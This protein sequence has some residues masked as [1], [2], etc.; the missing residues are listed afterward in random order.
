[1]SNK[2][3]AFLDEGTNKLMEV[4]SSADIEEEEKVA[5]IAAFSDELSSHIGSHSEMPDYEYIISK[6]SIVYVD[7]KL[8]KFSA[9]QNPSY[10][11]FDTSLSLCSRLKSL[12]SLFKKKGW[13]LPALTINDPDEFEASV[14]QHQDTSLR[15]DKLKKLDQQID[16]AISR[17]EKELTI[18]RCHEVVVLLD[19]MQRELELAGKKSFASQLKNS[20]TKALYKRVALLRKTAEQKQE[21]HCSII[22]LDGKLRA[23]DA[24][25]PITSVNSTAIQ[26]QEAIDIC[27]QL[28][29]LFAECKKKQWG[30]PPVSYE[31]PEI[32]RKKYSHYQAMIAI[33]QSITDCTD[34]LA[35]KKQYSWYISQCSKQV[36]NIELCRT[37]KWAIPTLHNPS[38]AGLIEVAKQKMAEKER[39]Q[40]LKG[41]LILAGVIALAVLVLIG[42][43]VVKSREGKITVPFSP[44]YAVSENCND[45][46]TELE[47]AGFTNIKLVESDDGWLESGDVIS[48]TVDNVDDYKKGSYFKPEVT[49]VITYSSSN[50]IDASD[51]LKDWQSRDYSSIVEDLKSEGFTQITTEA[52]TT[53]EKN[54]DQKIS[55]ISLND[56]AYTNGHCYLP[57]DAPIHIGYYELKIAA[58]NTNISFVGQNYTDV[59]NGLKEDGFTNV[60]TEEIKTGWAEGN[61]VIAVTFNNQTSYDS[62][63]NFSPDVKIVVKYSSNDRADA[64]ELLSNWSAMSYDKLQKSLKDAGFT[65]VTVKKTETTTKSQNHLVSSVKINGETF[66][67]GECHPQRTA[68]IEITYFVLKLTVGEAASDIEGDN[69]SDV[70]SNLKARGFTNITLKRTNDMNF[71]SWFT[72]EGSIKSISI[73]GNGDFKSDSKFYYDEEIIIIVNT[74]KDGCD[75]ITIVAK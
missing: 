54:K 58:P 28:V 7:E 16:I 63:D 6:I 11:D 31:D 39:A 37:N 15:T 9:T 48:V 45:I 23:I 71:F 70:V 19:E 14:R 52:I 53:Y 51:I 69:Y 62:S 72:K 17:A 33:D 27:Q 21:L 67:G 59:V 38:P 75:D 8:S 32:I 12:I 65:N 41:K 57:K 44:S 74:Y 49:V 64:T 34:I 3:D 50:R 66:N 43:I 35:T 40:K 24:I 26:W 42:F 13:P 60:Q 20:D 36:Q 73:G 1:M 68:P 25:P 22:E 10:K 29:K 61:S 56:L 5:I 18:D 46:K 47:A 4:L 2:Y 30:L 55:G